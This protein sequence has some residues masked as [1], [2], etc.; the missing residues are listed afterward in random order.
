MRAV[1]RTNV[2]RQAFGWPASR[3]LAG[4]LFSLIRCFSRQRC[5]YMSQLFINLII[6]AVISDIL[7]INQS[8]I[9]Y[10][11]HLNVNTMRPR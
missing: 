5:I 3:L 1:L 4:I 11:I 9:V 8:K 6:W 2:L 10:F 7:A